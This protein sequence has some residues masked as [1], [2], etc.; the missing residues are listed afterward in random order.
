LPIPGEA[1]ADIRGEGKSKLAEKIGGKSP[2]CGG[3]YYVGQAK[4]VLPSSSSSSSSSS[5]CNYY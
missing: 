5:S 4:V 2:L 3:A 1:G